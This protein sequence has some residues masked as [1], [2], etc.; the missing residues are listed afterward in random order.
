MKKP[1]DANY[2]QQLAGLRAQIDAADLA[3]LKALAR[4]RRIVEKIG[5]LKGRYQV[6]VLQRSRWSFLLRD[7]LKNARALGVSLSLVKEIFES[8]QKQSLQQ[9][10]SFSSSSSAPSAKKGRR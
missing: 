10:A 6:E 3:L 1:L 7:R 2:H 8:I 5:K 9:Q 4:R